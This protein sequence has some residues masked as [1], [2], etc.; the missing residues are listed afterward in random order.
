MPLAMKA[1]LIVQSF[2][3][4]ATLATPQEQRKAGVRDQVLDACLYTELP[5][6]NG[7]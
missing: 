6:G 3:G 4:V 2:G 7:T 1:G 5:S